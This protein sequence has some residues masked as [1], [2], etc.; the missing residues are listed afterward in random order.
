MP[1]L[2]ALLAGYALKVSPTSSLTFEHDLGYIGACE[3][4]S[5][6]TYCGGIIKHEVPAYVARQS[7]ILEFFIEKRVNGIHGD[8]M[9]KESVKRALCKQRFPVCFQSENRLTVETDNNCEQVIQKNCD[10]ESDSLLLKGLCSNYSSVLYE[11]SCRTLSDHLFRTDQVMAVCNLPDEIKLTDWMF[12]LILQIEAQS[13][14]LGA[15][16]HYP[17][18]YPDLVNYQCSYGYCKGDSI[19]S[20]NTQEGCTA[21]QEW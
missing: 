10:S 2:I 6:L 14:H 11:E 16:K 5:V 19:K 4:A 7:Q 13:E 15:V 18:C 9:C 8:G 20:N 1:I 12:H 21:M 17:H 3:T